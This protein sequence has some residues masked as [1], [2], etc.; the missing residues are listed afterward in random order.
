MGVGI[1]M[2]EKELCLNNVKRDGR[3]HVTVE[4]FSELIGA[5]TSLRE[6]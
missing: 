2:N 5:F 1:D 3:G 6:V 4:T